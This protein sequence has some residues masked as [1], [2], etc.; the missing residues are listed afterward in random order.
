MIFKKKDQP[1]S[2]NGDTADEQRERGSSGDGPRRC[3]AARGE[4]MSRMSYGWAHHE[5]DG[6]RV[7]YIKYTCQACGTDWEEPG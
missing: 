7:R 2:W 6:K 4:H 3:N 5:V 1:R